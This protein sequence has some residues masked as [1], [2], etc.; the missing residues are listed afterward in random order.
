MRAGKL[1]I[2]LFAT[3]L[4]GLMFSGLQAIEIPWLVTVL[5]VLILSGQIMLYL[6]EGISTGARDT[7]ISRRV[8]KQEKDGLHIMQ[9]DDSA[10]YSPVR[11]A[12]AAGIVF[13]VPIL[14]ALFVA[15]GSKPYT[16]EMQDLPSWMT[17][18]SSNR[19]DIMLPLGAYSSN[20]SMTIV[21][22]CRI[23][24]RALG[25]VF[26]NI[27]P[28]PLHQNQLIDRAMPLFFL[29]YPAGYMAGYFMGP[30]RQ[31]IMARKQRRAKKV[32]VK[33]AQRSSLAEEL[34]KTGAEVHYGQ[35]NDQKNDKNRLI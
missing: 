9:A 2:L 20:L 5:S 35:R 32:A 24:V 12:A 16:Y 33:K 29:L 25:M 13:A 1:L 23:G 7:E 8:E 30:R 11:A 27:F 15:L 14:L 28:D 21:D 34:T 17:A 31:A 3:T 4:I 26:V 6:N 19:T 18:G 10:C 22:W